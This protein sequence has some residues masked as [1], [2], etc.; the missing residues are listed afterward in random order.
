MQK[1]DAEKVREF[2]ELSIQEKV[3]GSPSPMSKSEVE[4]L[5]R[6]VQ[7]EL[8]ELAQTVTSSQLEATMMVVKSIGTDMSVQ[9]ILSDECSVIAAQGDAL[10]DAWY[11]MLNAAAKKGLNISRIMDIVHES[12]M[13]KRDP[14]TG[15]FI[16]RPEDGK[17]LKPA[18]WKP[19]DIESEIR[20]QM[21]NG[22]WSD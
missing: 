6:M 13:N 22:A 11:Y 10:V 19:A 20:S 2:T 1:S 14:S 21:L 3:P 5:L 9:P 12:N 15:Q 7:S 18:N 17:V 16:R 8:V 4:W